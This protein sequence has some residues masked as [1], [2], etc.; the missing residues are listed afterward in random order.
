[1]VLTMSI[2]DE[3]LIKMISDNEKAKQFWE[4]FLG[5]DI[6]DEFLKYPE[7]LSMQDAKRA[8]I[9]KEEK[10]F[11]VKCIFSV[12][13]ENG[14]KFEREERIFD[15]FYEKLGQYVKIILKQ[16]LIVALEERMIDSLVKQIVQR[17]FWIP[18]RCLIVDMHEKKDAEQLNGHSSTE[19]Y[20]DYVSKYLLN[21]REYREFLK[22]YPVMTDLLICKIRDYI[23]YVDEILQHFYQDRETISKEFHI[24]QNAME[25]TKISFN[26]DE[27]HF[28][29]RMVARVGLK[30]GQRIY[31]K[32]HSLLLT[33][34]YQKIENWLWEK[35]ELEKSRHLVVSG[36]DYGWEQEVT[37]SECKCTKEI[38]EFYYRCGAECCLTYVLGMTDI[39]MDNVIAHGK[40][41]VI[42]DTEFM[43]DRRI[44]VG[45]QGKNLQQNLMDT[46]MHTGFVPNGMGTMHVNVSVLN[47]CEEQR[48]PVKMPMVINKGT[49][50]MNI[51]YHYPKLSHKKNMPIYEGK[52]ISFEN[53]MDEFMN[54]FRKAYDCVKADSEVLTG[55]CQPIMK[56]KVRY[57]FR[58]TQEY[59]MYITSFNFPELMRN[60][61]KRQL[62]LWHMNRG[63]HCNETYRVK[64]LIY[65]MQCVYDGIVPIFYADGKNLL[66]GNGEYIENYFH[67]DNEQQLKLR[68]EKLSDWD[69]DFQTKVIQSALLMYDKKKENWNG[70]LGQPQSKIG[71]LTAER[72]AK[73]VFNATVLTGDKME[74]ISVIYGKDG[75]TK[76]GKADIYLYNGLSGILLFFE[77]MW[78]KEHENTY[79]S[80]VEQLKKQLFEH[81]DTLIQNGSNRQ[82]DMMG[83]FDGEFSFIF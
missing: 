38:K 52:H 79:H 49:S 46:V 54:G 30:G 11:F 59:Y 12:S 10:E 1:M 25:I 58:N 16:K 72:I 45:I 3:N 62:S 69:K 6:L 5:K 48:L 33:E 4:K 27:E 68:I 21:E 40:Y 8:K 76:A 36:D 41:P 81:T 34:Q 39:H 61:A 56:K 73:W 31:Y 28:P 18:F 50:E 51:S 74:W 75:W 67:K 35:M 13:T 57:L 65:E 37:E 19:E 17:V 32:P 78:Q 47:T 82:N 55:M 2:N 60:Q 44:E 66:M 70:Q 15:S 80:V 71:E 23:H 29:G 83:L 14:F 24:E 42:I 43:F 9:T 53:Y 63:L 7:L 64:I 77:A 20:D 26:Q 22:K